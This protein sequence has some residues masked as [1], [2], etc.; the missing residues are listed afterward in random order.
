MVAHACNPSTQEAKAGGLRFRAN[1]GCIARP[2]LKKRERE[3]ERE[4]ER[5]RSLFSKM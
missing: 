4:T 3:I 2:C 1:L 5:E